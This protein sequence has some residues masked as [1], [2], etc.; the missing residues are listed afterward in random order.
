M[1]KIVYMYENVYMCVIVKENM[2]KDPICPI[3]LSYLECGILS[4]VFIIFL[5]PLEY[6]RLV[7]LD[8]LGFFP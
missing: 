2:L 7:V 1:I 8:S 6:Y 4:L 3:F 5:Y